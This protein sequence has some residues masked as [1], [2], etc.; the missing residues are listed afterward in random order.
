MWK[1]FLIT[2]VVIIGLWFGAVFWL[3]YTV[4]SPGGYVQSYLSALEE[5][6]FGEAAAR[7]GLSELPPA[8]PDPDALLTEVVIGQSL[9]INDT[10]VVVS[11]Q[12]VLDGIP[13]VSLFTV[14]RLPRVLGLFDRWEF[15][16][17]PQAMVSAS[18]QGAD[19]V[20]INGVTLAEDMTRD[21]VGLLYPGRYTVSWASAWLEA[22]TVDLALESDRAETIRLF[23][24]PTPDLVSRAT[25]AVTTYLTSCQD[26]EVLQPSGCP[27]GVTLTDRVVGDVVWEV[28]TPPRVVLAMRDDETTWQVS[29]LG[30]EVTLLVSLQS[31]FDG[32]IEEYT[33]TQTVDITGVIENLD[34]D[35]PR[36]IVD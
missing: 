33:E 23:A 24:T 16:A 26:Q 7:A 25:D 36:F 29:A 21:G 3:N 22:D 32:T 1:K 5:G 4:F 35:R 18:V 28:S 31:L 17:A 10:E 12:Y 6:K 20:V 30:G 11:A 9:A 8:L 15:A 13:S 19:D 34:T 14:A 27:F 2:A